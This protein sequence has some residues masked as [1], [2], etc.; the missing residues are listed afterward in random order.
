VNISG[1]FFCLITVLNVVVLL[2]TIPSFADNALK[3]PLQ[4]GVQKK[5]HSK[6]VKPNNRKTG[7]AYSISK[8]YNPN[9]PP[10]IDDKVYP[11]SSNAH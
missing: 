6:L 5:G 1:K 3:K 4:G 2:S 8:P 7:T 10:P 11:V 9:N